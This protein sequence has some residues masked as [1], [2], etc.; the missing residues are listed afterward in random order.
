MNSRLVGGVL[1]LATVFLA[2]K[3][4]LFLTT[5]ACNCGTTGIIHKLAVILLISIIVSFS[6]LNGFKVANRL[7]IPTLNHR[8]AF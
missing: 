5:V 1:L 3:K 7:L 4:Q 6:F 2:W 8:S